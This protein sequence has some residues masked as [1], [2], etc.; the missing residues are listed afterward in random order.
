[1][2]SPRVL[3]VTDPG[4]TESLIE[5]VVL[6]VGAA[7]SPGAFGVLLRDKQRSRASVVGFAERLRKATSSV[8][9]PLVVHSDASL[10]V[11][12]K[13]DGVHLG[14]E[15]TKDDAHAL[16]ELRRALPG[17]WISVAAH[18]DASV[19]LAAREGAD[20]VLVS[21]IYET[22]GKGPV[23]GILALASARARAPKLFLYAL[24]GVDPQRAP[25]C[26]RAGADGIALIRALLAASDP[27]RVARA[28]D[29]AVMPKID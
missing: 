19:E 21:P 26:R 11:A 16:A 25:E 5:G 15:G 12:V 6:R 29:A 1:M 27:V 3:L 17:S 4:Y 22:P 28:I 8:G 13:A 14:G 23:R 24:G 7:L 2:K 10:A 20:A 9:A 18:D